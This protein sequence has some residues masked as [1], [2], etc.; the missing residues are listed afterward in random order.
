MLSFDG[1]DFKGEA[2]AFENP[3]QMRGNQGEE[4]EEEASP[5]DLSPDP[6]PLDSFYSFLEPENE[7]KLMRELEDFMNDM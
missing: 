5:N 6:L 7:S 3:Q 2:S 4:V 1:K